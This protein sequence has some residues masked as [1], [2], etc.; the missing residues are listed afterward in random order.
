[1]KKIYLLILILIFQNCHYDN[2]V[3]MKAYFSFL[4]KQD[5][6]ILNYITFSGWKSNKDEI[7]KSS[8]D[9]YLSYLFIEDLKDDQYTDHEP[10]IMTYIN[11]FFAI[12]VADSAY[13]IGRNGHASW[14]SY[15]L[16]K[17][18]TIIFT[19][20]LNSYSKFEM[21]DKFKINDKFYNEEYTITGYEDL[22]FKEYEFK[23]CLKIRENVDNGYINFW[24]D[25][26][27]GLIQF[28]SIVDS[29]Y[30]ISYLDKNILFKNEQKSITLERYR[31]NKN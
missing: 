9:I 8:K 19:Y 1:M 22:D 26:L 12:K 7:I 15:I 21:P 27:Y 14:N 31:K 6:C 13:Q 29:N 20:D 30:S 16:F 17:D 18:S 2:S 4:N 23:D 24:L 25:S 10:I 3:D 11:T 5:S 28:E